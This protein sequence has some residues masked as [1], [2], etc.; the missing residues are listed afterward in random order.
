[1]SESQG[2]GDAPRRRRL[3]GGRWAHLAG[4]ALIV[5]LGAGCFALGWTLR[6]P[7]GQPSA[8]A[9]G[10]L[11]VVAINAHLASAEPGYVYLA[12]DS[13]MELFAPEPLPCGREVVNGGVGGAKAGDY[14]RFLDR[15][16]MPKA[17]SSILLSIGLNNL[18]KKSNPGGEAALASFRSAAD[19]LVA[20]LASTGARIVIVAIPPLPEASV[21]FFDA[22]SIET[23]TQVLRDICTA[24]GCSVRDVFAQARDGAFWRAKPGLPSDGLHLANLRHYYRSLHAELC[25]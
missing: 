14:L 7:P 20:R 25:R 5:A 17:P 13:Y 6:P 3:P 23:Y 1:M 11:R 8:V 16:H 18:L 10:G 24:R 2:S 9:Y 4:A 15:I 19:A 21:K 12:G 22:A